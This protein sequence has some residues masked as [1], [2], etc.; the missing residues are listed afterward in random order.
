MDDTFGTNFIHAGLGIDRDRLLFSETHKAEQSKNTGGETRSDNFS[1]HNVGKI[2]TPCKDKN[3]K[4]SSP[5]AELEGGEKI[6]VDK[7]N[8]YERANNHLRYKDADISGL[9]NNG[10]SKNRYESICN[11]IC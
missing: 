6:S 1:N 2:S 4:T 8:L 9:L 7:N 11:G 5:I 3:E 10:H